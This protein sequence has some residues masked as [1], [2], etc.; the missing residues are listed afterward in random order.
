MIITEGVER[1]H[2]RQD[3]NCHPR[4]LVGVGVANVVDVTFAVGVDLGPIDGSRMEAI[5]SDNPLEAADPER[6]Q[7][8]VGTFQ[9]RPDRVQ[10]NLSV[11]R[12]R[13]SAWIRLKELWNQKNK[14]FK[15]QPQEYFYRSN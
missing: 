3:L 12:C 2:G 4:F 7:P 13:T 1:M 5:I 6:D 15:D 14:K 11:A 10:N 9:T 8:R